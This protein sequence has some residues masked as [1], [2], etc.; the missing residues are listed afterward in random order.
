MSDKFLGYGQGSVNLTNGS[1]TIFSATLGAAALTAS[2]PVK[3][4]S[5]KQLVSAN[6]DIPDINNLQTQLNEKDELTFVE[7]DTHNNPPSGKVKIYAKTDG[8]VYKLDS[9]GNET[10]LGGGGGVETTTIPVLDNA[11][12]FYDGTDGTKIKQIANIKYD[13][14]GNALV[15]PDLETTAT[16]SL[17]EELQLISNIES[18][19]QSPDIT[20][21]NGEIDVKVIKS[22][23]HNV[24]LEFDNTNAILTADGDI[25][26]I[27]GSGD[28]QLNGNFI[29]LNCPATNLT[30]NGKNVKFLIT[31]NLNT[32]GG[33]E[34]GV[35]LTTGFNNASVGYRSMKDLTTGKFNVACG[36][37]A[38]EKLTEGDSNTFVGSSSGLLLTTG[39]NNT[40]IG[41]G[42]S[43]YNTTGNN[44]TGIGASS[45]FSNAGGVDNTAVGYNCLYFNSA[46][47]NTAIGKDSMFNT[48]TGSG[49]VAMGQGSLSGNQTGGDNVFIGRAAGN[50]G[51][52]IGESVGIGAESCQQNTSG[53]TC[54][55]FR[56][57][58]NLTGFLNTAVGHESLRASTGEKN[59]AVGARALSNNTSGEFNTAFGEQSGNYNTS[60]S[61]NTFIGSLSGEQAA[62]GNYI[63]NVGYG[64][65]VGIGLN[66]SNSA[67]LGANSIITASNQI[68]LGDS[69]ITEIVSGTNGLCNLGSS[70]NKFNN[71]YIA[72]NVIGLAKKRIYPTEFDRNLFD[73][74][75]VRIWLDNAATD[76]IE[77]EITTP[78]EDQSTDKTY[79]ISTVR[80]SGSSVSQTGIAVAAPAVSTTTV[81]LSFNG[82]TVLLIHIFSPRLGTSWGLYEATI[83]KTYSVDFTNEP[84]ICSV[85]KL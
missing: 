51:N 75:I 68:V 59:S 79:Q 34:S 31:D 6:L 49:N 11:L 58:E 43:A 47:S 23:E 12:V 84:V 37:N 70:A 32:F 9:A 73:D 80:F 10:S 27:T 36:A 13:D 4:N 53:S 24:E 78:A 2:K 76:D 85:K 41:A 22:A 35:N 55:G 71:L 48:T 46:S 18:A 61:F 26:L 63:T 17:N 3:T 14:V 16:F 64:A 15:V 21:F 30:Y 25:Q 38:G 62:S 44:N 56:A 19:T 72:G 74:G 66:P 82:G 57:G 29:T 45:L 40:A 83:I 81:D 69:N 77:V 54:V 67:S 1:A 8:G 33:I 42:S 50:V 7:D 52:L 28:I 5:V 20:V 39:D 60:G 65:R